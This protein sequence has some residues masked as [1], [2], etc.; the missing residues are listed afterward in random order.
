VQQHIDDIAQEHNEIYARYPLLNC[1]SAYHG[2]DEAVAEYINAM[3][4]VK[5]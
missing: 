1:L 4:V 5:K 3:D 2:N